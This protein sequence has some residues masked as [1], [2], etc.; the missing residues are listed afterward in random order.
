M[1]TTE[2]HLGILH[3]TKIAFVNTLFEPVGLSW[4]HSRL[5]NPLIG[6]ENLNETQYYIL[7]S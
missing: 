1:N 6:Q 7:L 3:E 5:S 4:K 2:P